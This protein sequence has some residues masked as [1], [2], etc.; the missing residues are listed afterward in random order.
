M[1]ANVETRELT[2]RELEIVSGGM[3]LRGD[4]YK[5]VHQWVHPLDIVSKVPALEL[6][7]QAIGR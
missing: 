2:A 5:A 7:I 6:E 1:T 3:L 4:Q